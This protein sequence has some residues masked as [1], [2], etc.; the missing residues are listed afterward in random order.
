LGATSNTDID[1]ARALDNV[2]HQVQEGDIDLPPIVGRLSWIARYK[3]RDTNELAPTARN[4]TIGVLM[5]G[6]RHSQT[7]PATDISIENP[8]KELK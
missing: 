2:S 6:I 5:D 8:K 1:A 4:E 7:W 3:I